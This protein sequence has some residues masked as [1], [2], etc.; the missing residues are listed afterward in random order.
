MVTANNGE[1]IH[2]NV[3]CDTLKYGA[4]PLQSINIYSLKDD[5]ETKITKATDNILFPIFIHG[6]AWR[7][8]KITKNDGNWLMSNLVASN[9]CSRSA[10]IEY[11]LSPEVVDPAHMNDVALA[12]ELLDE[13]FSLGNNYAL[14]GHSA[15]AFISFQLLTSKIPNFTPPRAIFGIDGIYD[16]NALVE[17]Y[18]DY[19]GFVVNAFTE[20]EELWKK[21]S[22]AN[23]NYHLVQGSYRS[24]NVS[25]YS[26]VDNASPGDS[27]K[28]SKSQAILYD[29]YI[30][31][32]Q[33]ADDELL[34]WRQTNIAK[35]SL[36]LK[37]S[38]PP[39]YDLKELHGLHD[40]VYKTDFFL[41]V[42]QS[43]LSNCCI[44]EQKH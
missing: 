9:A 32:G 34:S 33:S 11:R 15:G 5:A 13:K 7:D 17:E 22:P 20:D 29:G 14:I 2:N 37:S 12:I 24:S 26:T 30:L 19:R 3:K 23:G 44:Q 35:E 42:I 36:F 16:L 43:C 10:S 21:A 40:E 41:E 38:S 25:R 18:P 31:L 1:E 28:S 8:P 6:G 4:H 39:R 27:T